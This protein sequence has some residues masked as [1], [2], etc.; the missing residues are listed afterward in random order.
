MSNPAALL[1]T[2]PLTRE[3]FFGVG[4]FLVTQLHSGIQSQ[5]NWCAKH[6]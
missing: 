5:T 6:R 2:A 3:T 4:S 1:H